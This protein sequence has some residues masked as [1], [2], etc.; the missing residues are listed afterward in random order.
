VSALRDL[1]EGEYVVVSVNPIAR[2][3][4]GPAIATLVAIAAVL[5][6][7]SVWTWARDQAVW[8]SLV[9]IAPCAAVLGGRI[10]RWRSHKIVVTNQRVIV[11]S[12][13][14]HRHARSV[15]LI[16]V[17]SSSVDQRW[18]ER[19]TRRGYVILD[20]PSGPFALE[21]VRRPDAL[22]RIIDHQRHQL[23]RRD[24]N[25]LERADEL[26]QARDSGLLSDDEY[27]ER[28][29]HLFGPGDSRS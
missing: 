2:G 16:D 4:T 6:A 9:F 25:R 24:Q 8:L 20:T 29:R 19:L 13:V 3:L 14:A 21:R 12:G 15:D 17:V 5:A 22:W 10:W 28:W 7:A 27:D 11:T 23:D 1:R 26:S 18:H